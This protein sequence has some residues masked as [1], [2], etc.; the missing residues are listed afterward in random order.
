M[1]HAGFL[2]NL[3]MMKMLLNEKNEFEMSFDWVCFAFV[4]V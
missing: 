4:F 1:M 3:E 2:G